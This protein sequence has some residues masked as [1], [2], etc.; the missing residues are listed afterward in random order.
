MISNKDYKRTKTNILKNDQSIIFDRGNPNS[1]PTA[2]PDPSSRNQGIRK[3]LKSSSM[4][5]DDPFSIYKSRNALPKT[6]SS[7]GTHL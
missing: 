7:I 5:M 4:I 1:T 6:V 2:P 3:F